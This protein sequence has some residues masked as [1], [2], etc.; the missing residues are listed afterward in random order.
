MSKNLSPH[1][2]EALLQCVEQLLQDG[3]K[4]VTIGRLSKHARLYQRTIEARL[5]RYGIRPI[6]VAIQAT[7]GFWNYYSL[8]E[9]AQAINEA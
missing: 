3:H 1:V 2:T 7:G 8:S 6:R 9:I 5:V 4:D